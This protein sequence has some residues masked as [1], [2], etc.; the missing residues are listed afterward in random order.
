MPA[1]E[2]GRETD[3]RRTRAA[4]LALAALLAACPSPGRAQSFDT[5]YGQALEARRK[6]EFDEA[7]RLLREA[8]RLGPTNADALLLLGTI[9]GF[10]NR[11][12][13]AE[14]TLR[15]AL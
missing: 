15:D 5:L 8:L 2:P 4:A 9:Y 14:R 13:E 1:G 3:G 10:Q 7:I 12:A 11:F 6:G